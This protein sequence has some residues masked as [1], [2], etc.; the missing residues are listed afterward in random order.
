L[1]IP[2]A[3]L[4]VGIAAMGAPDEA[5]AQYRHDVWGTLAPAAG[6]PVGGSLPAVHAQGVVAQSPVP[7]SYARVAS[8]TLIGG[9]L[10]A[11]AGLGLAIIVGQE[12]DAVMFPGDLAAGT[13]LGGV[14]GM[15]AGA[16]IGSGGRGNPWATGAA[17]VGSTVLGVLAGVT[18]G[19]ALANAGAG[20][21]PEIIGVVLGAGIPLAVT[22]WAEWRTAR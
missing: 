11:T 10:G 6:V 20:R 9:V 18:A 7:P 22:S 1:R 19:D 3:L 12:R 2:A 5:Q 4:G 13:M 14:A 16:R 21:S 8:G 17:V 15:Y